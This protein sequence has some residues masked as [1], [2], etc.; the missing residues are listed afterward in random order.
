MGADALSIL[1]S[2]AF[3]QQGSF[4]ATAE[5]AILDLDTLPPLEEAYAALLD[6][7]VAEGLSGEHASLLCQDAMQLRG[8]VQIGGN[9]N[10]RSVPVVLR[11][12]GSRLGEIDPDIYRRAVTRART[13]GGGGLRFGTATQAAGVVKKKVVQALP[14]A[15]VT[16]TPTGGEPAERELSL[17]E[18]IR[19]EIERIEREGVMEALRTAEGNVTRAA[20]ILG[21]SRKNMQ[22][23]M[24][25]FGIGRFDYKQQ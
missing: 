14:G 18:R 8:L 3:V 19:K 20:E 9:R 13:F 25:R 6:H 1:W 22:L 24:K 23:R 10:R 16:A 7:L 2:G 5:G 4:N 11:R 17:K 21:I 15:E 12:I